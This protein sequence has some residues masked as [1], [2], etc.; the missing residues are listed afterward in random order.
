LDISVETSLGSTLLRRQMVKDFLIIIGGKTWP[1][2]LVVSKMLGF[3][4]ILDMYLLSK[5][6]TSID[7][8]QKE[9]IFRPPSKI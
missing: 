5:H 8:S 2:D 3:N 6:Y 4:T 7:C 9:V 1:T